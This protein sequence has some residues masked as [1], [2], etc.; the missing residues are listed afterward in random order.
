[1]TNWQAR[2]SEYRKALTEDDEGLGPLPNAL[3][4]PANR[5]PSARCSPHPNPTLS[6]S[7]TS[8]THSFRRAALRSEWRAG[9][10][11]KV[12][13]RSVGNASS[14]HWVSRPAR[15]SAATE[16]KQRGENAEAMSAHQLSENPTA[17][18]DALGY[19]NSPMP[20]SASQTEHQD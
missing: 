19:S 11:V 12:A 18:T 1:M 20:T 16:R 8:S 6:P 17:D 5:I 14:A 15:G 10:S 13:G 4:A 3:A 2:S 9:A 7:P